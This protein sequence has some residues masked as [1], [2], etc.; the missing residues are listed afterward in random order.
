M[1]IQLTKSAQSVQNVLV[2]QGL[3]CEVKESKKHKSN[4]Q[5]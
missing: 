2:D 5:Q 1:A 4:V 3:N